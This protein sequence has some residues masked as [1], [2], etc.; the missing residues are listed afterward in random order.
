MKVFKTKALWMVVLVAM[1]VNF[2][3]CGPSDK[4]L[5]DEDRVRNVFINTGS[6]IYGGMVL[7]FS[8]ESKDAID[9]LDSTKTTDER[10]A[11]L[12]EALPKDIIQVAT[13][14]PTQ[15]DSVLSEL[16]K[17]YPEKFK[18]YFNS[19]E[20]KNALE[21][22]KNNPIPEGFA[23]FERKFTSEDVKNYLMVSAAA[24]DATDGEKVNPK[25]DIKPYVDWYTKAHKK[26]D[27]YPE[28]DEA[29]S[30]KLKRK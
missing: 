8:Q 27:E 12:E 29:F 17:E 23:S 10:V 2:Y 11:K 6:L 5:T 21:V 25:K 30:A 26:L 3:G 4:P 19:S 28:L 20:L 24:K 15:L 18:E 7:A 9:K 22:L 1:S 14:T 16:E 13:S